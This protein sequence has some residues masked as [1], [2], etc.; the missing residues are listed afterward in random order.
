MT[1][2]TGKR[3][4]VLGGAGFLGS[5]LCDRLLTEGAADVIA[6]DNLLSGSERNLFELRAR[7]GFRFVFHDLTDSPPPIGGEIQFVF[8]LA[9]PSSN[10][11]RHPIETLRAGSVGTEHALCLAR[12]KSAV[13]VQASGAQIYGEP[14]VHPQGEEYRGSV[15]VSAARACRDEARRF[16]EA[17]VAAWRR[18]Y[19]V[20]TRIA[21]I[22]NTYGP[23]M[24]PEDDRVLPTFLVQALQDEELTVFGDG[25][26]TRSFCYVT[27]VV[28][29]LLRLALSRAREPVNLGS[30]REIAILELAEKVRALSGTRAPVA[31]LPA[32]P[33]EVRRRQPDL[34]RARELLGWCPRVPLEEGLRQTSCHLRGALGLAVERS[35]SSAP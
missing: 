17:M 35:S 29:G 19:G 13:F 28:D 3:A 31:F 2:F 14:L 26:Q 30:A 25:S 27:D 18:E 23:R 10:W 16:A 34:T 24:R 9:S 11:E 33:D 8:N 5:H 6:V 7:R 4:V 12:E 15:N 32:R 1:G 22:F 20:E 21:R